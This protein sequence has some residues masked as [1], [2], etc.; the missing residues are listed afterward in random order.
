MV[1]LTTLGGYVKFDN[2]TFSRITMCGSIVKNWG[3]SY[4]YP[5]FSVITNTSIM[6]ENQKNF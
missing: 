2:T 3:A 5:S 4:P 6:S 1:N